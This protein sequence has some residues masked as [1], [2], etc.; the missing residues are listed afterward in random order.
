M[1]IGGVEA[2]VD[3]RRGRLSRRVEGVL[4]IVVSATAF[5]AMA[6]LANVAYDGGAEPVG[7]LW[8]RFLIAAG[9]LQLV[10]S[11]SSRPR[12]KG[13]DVAVLAALGA[14]YVGQ[15]FTFFTAL[16]YASASVVS[17]LLYLYPAIVTVMTA[18]LFRTRIGG[19]RLAALAV[20][21]VGS[22]LVI[23]PGGDA[24]PVGI[25]L[26]V[27]AAFVYASYIVGS[28]RVTG[29]VGPL[30][31][32]AVIMTS[33]AVIYTVLAAVTRPDLPATAG[34]WSAVVAIGLLC[35]VV[36]ALTFFA[37]L[38]RLGATDASTLSTLEPVV[39]VVLATVLLGDPLR[40]LQLVGGVLIL[41][42][43]VVLTRAAP[44]PVPDDVPPT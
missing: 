19:P 35:T 28:A 2:Q 6:I 17:M 41:A 11:R 15:S 33:S 34:S 1:T 13:R 25:A 42:A 37:G 24:K 21:L 40:P 26:G 38:E 29:E 8:L 31:S 3:E 18:V 36:A 12:P 32:T 43:V 23:G 14:G 20:A 30:Q 4:L 44:P 10:A 16:T 27:T 5:G 7:V 39:T 9:V 22:A